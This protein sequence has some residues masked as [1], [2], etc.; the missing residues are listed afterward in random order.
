[1]TESLRQKVPDQ[2]IEPATSWIP[3]GWRIKLTQRARSVRYTKS[4]SGIFMS[5]EVSLDLLFRTCRYYVTM[6]RDITTGVEGCDLW[7][8]NSL[9]IFSLFSSMMIR[10][11]P[12]HVLVHVRLTN[13]RLKNQQAKMINK[14]LVKISS[15]VFFSS[16]CR[17]L[18]VA[19]DSDTRLAF[20]WAYFH[21]KCLKNQWPLSSH[22]GY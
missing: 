14:R 9:E 5:W 21:T 8:W 15:P 13:Y 22:F 7:L 16:W 11:D 4:E 18:A 12:F 19:C 1:M 3:V 2:R 20:H 6:R 17:R 10:A